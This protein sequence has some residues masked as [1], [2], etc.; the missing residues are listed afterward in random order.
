MK[1]SYLLIWFKGGEARATGV[2]ELPEALAYEGKNFRPATEYLG[3]A[4]YLRDE[5]NR[6]VGFSYILGD[7]S[8]HEEAFHESLLAQS[9]SVKRDD[10]MLMIL[11]APA[12]FE[13][14]CVQ[15]VGT[16]LYRSSTNE[17]M[18]A[19]PNWDFGELA[20]QLTTTDTPLN[21]GVPHKR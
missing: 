7:A 8:E 13:I 21:S 1:L 2:A 18:L 6:L 10:G 9:K 4:D 3:D 11:L 20:F 12:T 19:I 14:Q 5:Q 16:T 15:A 17:V